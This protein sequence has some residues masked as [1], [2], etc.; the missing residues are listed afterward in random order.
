M[1]GYGFSRSLEMPLDRARERVIETKL[2]R[3]FES[4]A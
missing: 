3:V 1:I 2:K 4:A